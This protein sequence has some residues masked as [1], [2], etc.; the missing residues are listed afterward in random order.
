WNGK[1]G[2]L[3][4]VREDLYLVFPDMNIRALS[5]EDTVSFTVTYEFDSRL[6]GEITLPVH[7][8]ALDI[9]ALE[10]V[11]N[12]QPLPVG[13]V[14]EDAA[15]KECLQHLRLHRSLFLPDF[16]GRFL[17]R[18]GRSAGGGSG[19][20]QDSQSARTDE[21][22]KTMSMNEIF[23]RY[24]PEESEQADFPLAGFNLSLKPGRNTLVVTY[25]QRFYVEE[26][27]HG[28]FK[29][30]PEKGV[31]GIDYLLY[32]IQTWQP[33]ENFKFRVSVEIPDFHKKKLLSTSRKI[34]DIRS[35]LDLQA[36]HDRKQHIT[37]LSGDFDRIPADIFTLLV[38]VDK[39]VPDYLK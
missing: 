14:S 20:D 16:Y 7:F 34:P 39:K 1:E 23:D 21:S 3:L 26:R 8:I 36:I 24:S 13:F 6:S 9:Q 38:W 37:R 22:L 32:P 29:S 30:W 25:R 11:L 28:Y 4:L 10:V 15:K 2:G 27:G 5:P 19:R 18:V 35:N 31:T 33:S 17:N 12:G